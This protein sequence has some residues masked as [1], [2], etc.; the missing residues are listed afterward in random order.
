[1]FT[2]LVRFLKKRKYKGSTTKVPC[3]EV[4]AHAT[5]SKWGILAKIIR[6]QS[7]AA[8]LGRSNTWRC[9]L[10][11]S[12]SV[13]ITADCCGTY[14]LCTGSTFSVISWAWQKP[15]RFCALKAPVTHSIAQ[16]PSTR[17]L[18]FLLHSTTTKFPN[19]FYWSAMLQYCPCCP[20]SQ[21][22]IFW[23]QQ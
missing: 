11:L 15:A 7:S 1:M 5:G 8:C 16:W 17:F 14:G 10:L 18:H 6:Q 23:S 4:A 2:R 22:H 19:L 20:S 13:I 9:W 3:T 12:A 21:C